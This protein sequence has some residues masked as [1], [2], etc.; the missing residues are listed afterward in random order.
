MFKNSRI[1][2]INHIRLFR[3]TAI[4]LL[5]PLNLFAQD[6]AYDLWLL[7]QRLP[8]WAEKVFRQ[9]VSDYELSDFV[10]PFYLEGDFNGDS[11]IDIVIAVQNNDNQKKGLIIIHQTTHEIYPIGAGVTFAHFDDLWWMDIFKINYEMNNH[12]L[13]FQKDGDIA[14]SVQ[15]RLSSTSI[16]VGKSESSSGLIYW[17]GQ[18]YKWAQ[19]GD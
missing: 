18:E 5:L 14:D 7:H 15:L 2:D 1:K 4:I 19:M 10:N 17:D 12:E 9:N 6:Q 8:D 11:A 16:Y 3:L 13:T